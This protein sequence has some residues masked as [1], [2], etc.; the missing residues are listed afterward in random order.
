M[1]KIITLVILIIFIIFLGISFYKKW[2]ELKDFLTLIWFIP[3]TI[4]ALFQDDI[5]R[6]I[7]AP[8]LEI[9]FELGPPYCLKTTMKSKVTTP[10]GRI[11]RF[12]WD[13]YYFR[14]RVKNRGGSQA[15]LCECVAEKLWVYGDG[16]WSEDKT[17]QA[18]NLNWSN[19]KT[20]DEFLNINPN[21]PGWFCDLVHLENIPGKM[22][23][24]DYRSPF[25]NSQ[26]AEI[27][28][29]IK[30]KILVVIYSENNKS[31]SR[32]FEIHW[33]GEWRDEPNEMFEQVKIK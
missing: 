30:H 20:Q 26:Y 8:K 27:V 23:S 18:V 31:V 2:V 1:K 11:Q 24:I 25:P 28:P 5:K 21:S 14:F 6:F 22:M 13:A 10:D 12:K 17:F 3:L 4:A 33:T 9:E 19:S 16:G 29:N 32:E 15:K 7:S